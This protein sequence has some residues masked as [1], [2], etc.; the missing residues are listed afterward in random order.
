MRKRLLQALVV[1][2]LLAGAGEAKATWHLYLVPVVLVD[3]AG[4]QA[5]TGK[6]SSLASS[7]SCMDYGRQ[8]IMLCAF[9]V[10]DVNDQQLTGFSDVHRL[11]DN[12]DQR[13]PIQA[14]SV[15]QAA[16]ENRNIPAQWVDN[17]HTY[18]DLLRITRGIFALLQR[19]IAVSGSNNIVL[20]G[21]VTLNTTMNQLSAAMRNNLR[22]SATQLNA[23]ISNI[24]GNT[25]LREALQIVG[26]QFLDTSFTMGGIT[27]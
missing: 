12:L 7:T 14:V 24:A 18:R 9:N 13:I 5:R 8:A 20:G 27:I 3:D 1:T 25:P 10:S 19:Y 17:L 23:D 6:Y 11:P 15:V 2:A 22:A 26:E 16:L 4:E 21:S